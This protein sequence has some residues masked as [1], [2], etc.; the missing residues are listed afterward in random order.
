M[1][2]SNENFSSEKE[3][4]SLVL[5]VLNEASLSSLSIS[6]QK[7]FR[8]TMT[9]LSRFDKTTDDAAIE[10]SKYIIKYETEVLDQI[11]VNGLIVLVSMNLLIHEKAPI[12]NLAI[13]WLLLHELEAPIMNA[14]LMSIAVQNMT[15]TKVAKIRLAIQMYVTIPQLRDHYDIHLNKHGLIIAHRKSLPGEPE[16]YNKEQRI[17]LCRKLNEITDKNINPFWPAGSWRKDYEKPKLNKNGNIRFPKKV[18]SEEKLENPLFHLTF[19]SSQIA[20]EEPPKPKSTSTGDF[21][22]AREEK[23]NMKKKKKS[24]SSGSKSASTSSGYQS[25]SHS[26]DSS[27]SSGQT[28]FEYEIKRNND[29]K[30]SHD[31]PSDPHSSQPKQRDLEN[32][33]NHYTNSFDNYRMGNEQTTSY[34]HHPIPVNVRRLYPLQSHKNIIKQ[35]TWPHE[36]NKEKYDFNLKNVEKKN[37]S[38]KSDRKS[39]FSDV[40]ISLGFGKEDWNEKNK[41]VKDLS[42]RSHPK[43]HFGVTRNTFGMNSLY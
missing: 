7:A 41:S 34:D 32:R 25:N 11:N 24:T 16:A 14:L 40:S 15:F 5:R 42:G 38:T 17:S 21:T 1:E 30:N 28:V 31:R 13:K 12:V 22:R 36:K 39:H 6:H 4:R 43:L 26:S 23:L 33:Y 3:K 8:P 9:L 2:K 20:V 37:D 35:D 27:S 10:V 29:K 19:E 18:M